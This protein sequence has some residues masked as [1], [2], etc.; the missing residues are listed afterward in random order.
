[1]GNGD[2]N[3]DKCVQEILEHG[4]RRDI[5]IVGRLVEDQDIGSADQ[6]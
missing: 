3:A 1:M 5:H 2:H 6:D 4:Q